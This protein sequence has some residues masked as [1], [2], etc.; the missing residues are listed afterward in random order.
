MAPKP[1]NVRKN[2]PEKENQEQFVLMRD[3]ASQ[4]LILGESK[5]TL[6]VKKGVQLAPGITVS[7]QDDNRNRWRGPVLAIG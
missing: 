2:N 4:V 3:E 7:L 1:S 6:L 5:K